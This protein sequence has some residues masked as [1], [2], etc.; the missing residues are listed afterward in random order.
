[1]S[2]LR[3]ILGLKPTRTKGGVNPGSNLATADT[4]RHSSFPDVG[5]PPYR[6][7]NNPVFVQSESVINPPSPVHLAQAG[8]TQADVQIET[9]LR[10]TAGEHPQP[11]QTQSADRRI[12]RT[13]LQKAFVY[14][15]PVGDAAAAVFSLATSRLSAHPLAV[16]ATGAL[17]GILWTGSAGLQELANSPHSNLLL[18]INLLG[19]A[20]GILSTATSFVMGADTTDVAYGSA[21]S[22]AANGSGY[23]VRAAFHTGDS[24]A[25]RALSGASG[26]ANLA[27]AGLSAAAA[28]TSANGDSA[29]A[30]EFATLSAVFWY[31]GSSAGLGAAWASRPSNRTDESIMDMDS[32]PNVP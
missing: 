21:A 15:A 5:I 14:G 18:G 3:E 10:A 8:P 22:W 23:I 6:D 17:S 24:I 28:R 30:A 13:T 1:M 20:A 12:E 7:N 16:Q 19:G 31:I 9:Q 27:A 29:K 25:A 4:A 26:V 32:G 11:Q 2:G